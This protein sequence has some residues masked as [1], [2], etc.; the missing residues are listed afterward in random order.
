MPCAIFR[1]LR[2]KSTIDPKMSA[3][4]RVLW[5]VDNMIRST[6]ISSIPARTRVSLGWSAHQEHRAKGWGGLHA[7]LL[8]GEHQ[9]WS[10]AAKVARIWTNAAGPHP[11]QHF[12]FPQSGNF[13]CDEFEAAL[14]LLP[15]L[16]SLIM[17]SP[18]TR[19]RVV[20][21]GAKFR[22]CRARFFP[23]L[24]AESAIDPEMSAR[25]PW[26]RKDGRPRT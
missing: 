17:S 26:T 3:G 12:I 5:S 7:L 23:Y 18:S 4:R 14:G 2:A 25:P 11:E 21:S 1:Y 20:T 6:S 16:T 24:R 19:M 8:H 10:S 15:G 9:F 13:R 22:Y